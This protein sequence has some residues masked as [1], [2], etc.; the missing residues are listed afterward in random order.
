MGHWEDN[1]KTD[2]W[3]TPKYIF[4][5][6][7]CR[8]DMDVASPIDKS[9][10]HVP[11]DI[12]LT[13]NSLTTEWKGFVWCNPPFGSRNG[14]IPWLNKMA[15]HKCGILLAPD[16]TSAPWWQL[17]ASQC[18]SLLLIHK[19]VKFISNH[20]FVGTK[21]SNGVT[22]FGYGAD[23]NRALLNAQKNNLGLVFKNLK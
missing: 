5:A 22:L 7:N 8:F 2:E 10:C 19:K 13:E 4:D 12:Y 18:D 11:A 16:R 9:L 14:I 17:A 23:A 20:G 21:P 15:I 3:Y 1:G 6:L